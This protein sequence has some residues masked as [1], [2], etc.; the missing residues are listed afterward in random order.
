MK[1]KIVLLT[2][3]L[4]A[5]GAS[6]ADILPKGGE[7]GT[8]V[9]PGQEG[10]H[11]ELI[12]KSI[13]IVHASYDLDVVAPGT[14]FSFDI[15][16]SGF[17]EAFY[18]IIT[19]DA[20]ALDVT[21]KNLRLVTPN[22]IRGQIEVGP[23]ATTQY[24]HP[25]VVIR[26][27]PVF[28]APDPFGVV[29][30]NEVL[31]IELT[32]ID[33]TGQW[34]HFR[35]TTN[36]NEKSFQSFHLQPTNSMLE[37]S[38]IKT[39]FPFYVDGVVMIGEGLKH[40]QYGLV[41]SMGKHEIFRQDPLVDVVKPTVGKTG[42]IEKVEATEKAHR[43]GDTL[44]LA[45]KGSAFMP[46]E[47]AGLSV[48][49]TPTDMGP[50]TLTF[51]SVGR[52]QATLPIPPNTPP[53]VY[54]VKVLSNGKV[55]QEQQNVFGIVPPNW[56]STVKLVRELSP[57]KNGQLQIIGR[58]IAPEYMQTLQLSTDTDGLKISNLRWQDT[59]TLVAD[60][61]VASDVTPGNYLIHISA[62]G[63]ALKL[64]RGNIITIAP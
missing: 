39:Q 8:F 51:V 43:P 62:G 29:R 18:K 3:F 47:V 57:G 6:H 50:A 45:I 22:Q 60:I 26:S 11:Q 37:V 25:L 23:E 2:F 24:I 61:A 46:N 34:G 55:L 13:T 56:L 54:G 42:S 32:S 44:E 49:V 52:I 31:D 35:V 63:K 9:V 19:V 28:R 53:G 7:Q 4:V 64:P 5:T 36:L 38:N 10:M 1:L 20:D 15:I 48:M 16:G 17:D 40:G 59:S 14:T 41:A 58:D 27:L 21:V 30:P 12:P 33:E